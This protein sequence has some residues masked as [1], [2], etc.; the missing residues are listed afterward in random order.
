MYARLP[1]DDAQTIG[2]FQRF[3][4]LCEA[5]CS[6]RGIIGGSGDH[7][8]CQRAVF[9]GGDGTFPADLKHDPSVAPNSDWGRL[10]AHS[11]G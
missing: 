1:N 4:A 5:E 6:A 2:Y 11:Y 10:I 8:P 7:T 9:E 3:A